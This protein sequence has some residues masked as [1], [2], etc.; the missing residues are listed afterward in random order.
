MNQTE[1]EAKFTSTKEMA[2]MK[3]YEFDLIHIP[4][5]GFA[6]DTWRAVLDK[7]GFTTETAKE[8]AGIIQKATPGNWYL[9]SYGGV[10]FAEAVRS[11]MKEGGTV[12]AGQS[13][14]FLA[15]ANNRWVTDNIM[16]NAGVTV[17][18]Y[19]GSWFDLVPN[20]IGL[21]SLNP[22]QLAVNIL[23]SPSLFF[24]SMSFHSY[25]PVK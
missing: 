25:P 20:F 22:I 8:L 17:R 15:G 14:T 23:V 21:N 11:I 10:A 4:T 7:M 13:V 1:E 6:P 2:K 5:L 24:P 19:P 3:K 9:H 16:R 18:G 12:P